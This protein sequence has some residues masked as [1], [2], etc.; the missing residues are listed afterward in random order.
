[1]LSP[2]WSCAQSPS[3]RRPS[4]AA[5]SIRRKEEDRFLLLRFCLCFVLISLFQLSFIY[6]QIVEYQNQWKRR[7][8][9]A[10]KPTYGWTKSQQLTDWAF[11][12]AGSSVGYFAFILYGTTRECANTRRRLVQNIR[13]WWAEKKAVKQKKEETQ[14]ILDHGLRKYQLQQY[15]DHQHTREASP[16]YD[17]NPLKRPENVYLEETWTPLYHPGQYPGSGGR[18]HREQH[19]ERLPLRIVTIQG[20]NDK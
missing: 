19:K 4:A 13:K 11:F 18:P 2:T 1:M 15:D 16:A 20:G 14:N 6:S 8:P 7:Q 5:S 12:F 17:M 10:P 3:A 9:D